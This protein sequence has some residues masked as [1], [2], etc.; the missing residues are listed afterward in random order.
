ML[1]FT[2]LTS[3]NKCYLNFIEQVYN[4]PCGCPSIL[5]VDDQFINRFIIEEYCTRYNVP[6][7]VSE[8]GKDAVEKVLQAGSN[9]C[10]RG[11]YLVLMDLNMP[12][13]GGIEA[14]RLIIQARSQRKVSI[15]L[16]VV[17]RYLQ[18]VIA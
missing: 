8:D 13:M 6:Y 18:Y 11:Y 9:L 5:I 7:D 14:T 1:T 16:K 15:D 17:G 2:T 3:V 12:I 4:K 10:C